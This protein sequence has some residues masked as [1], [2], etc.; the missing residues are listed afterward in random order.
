[1]S[2]EKQLL[3]ILAADAAVF[4]IAGDNLRHEW[5]DQN[6]RDP[7][8]VITAI[9]ETPEYALDLGDAFNRSRMQVDCFAESFELVRDLAAAVR[10]AL[11]GYSGT[12]GSY[13]I[14]SITFEN[15][16]SLGEQDGDR[17]IRRISSDF[18]ITHI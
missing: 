11:H 4:A 3:E 15:S 18:L 13:S 7:G 17:I 10:A 1:M 12:A 9:S 8:V 16:S 5:R 6:D 14:D 2:L